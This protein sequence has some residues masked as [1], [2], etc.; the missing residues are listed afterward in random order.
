MAASKLEESI[1]RLTDYMAPLVNMESASKRVYLS[2][3][4][5]AFASAI[6]EEGRERIPEPCYHEN[7]GRGLPCPDCN[8]KQKKCWCNCCL[9][10][11][12]QEKDC[13]KAIHPSDLPAEVQNCIEF[14][15]MTHGEPK[16]RV[17]GLLEALAKIC[18]GARK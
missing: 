5:R 7:H 11:P 8:E 1:E 3:A 12:H 18:L 14:I 6:R 10:I 16:E 2:Q 15:L 9:N 4:L 17:R 13:H